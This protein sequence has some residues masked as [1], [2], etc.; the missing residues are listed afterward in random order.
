M[1]IEVFDIVVTME[2][3][4]AAA[5]M[6]CPPLRQILSLQVRGVKREGLEV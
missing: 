1:D 2:L 5:Y 6:A 4:G 3:C